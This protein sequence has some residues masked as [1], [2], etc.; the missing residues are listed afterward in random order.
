MER[1]HAYTCGNYRNRA[2]NDYS[3]T[4]HYIRK[5]VIKELVLADLQRVLSYVKTNESGFIQTATQHGDEEVKKKISNLKT[6]A[7]VLMFLQNNGITDLDHL[8]NKVTR[9]NEEFLEVSDNI[10]KADRRL[11]TLTQHLAQYDNYKTHKA[12]YDKYKQFDPKKQ[13]AFYE[14]HSEKIE[15]FKNAQ[16]YLNAVMNGKTG[17]PVKS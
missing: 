17:V 6:Q 9:M 16:Q 15:L 7:S 12:I 3:C 11:D 14:R 4:T 2:R 10:K 8:V 13:E 1:K 5:T